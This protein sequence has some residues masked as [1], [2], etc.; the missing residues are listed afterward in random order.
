MAIPIVAAI[1]VV[2]FLYY[3][4]RQQLALPLEA[5]YN[6]EI[7]SDVYCTSR[8]LRDEQGQETNK[9]PAD[10]PVQAPTKYELAINLKTAKA[11][12]ISVP[13]SL[14]S[15]ADDVIE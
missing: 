15:R 3:Y 8:G 2:S 13:A 1:V 6:F 9:K 5:R 7:G 4:L 14:L 10:L 11:L 12:G